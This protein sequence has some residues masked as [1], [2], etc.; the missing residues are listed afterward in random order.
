MIRRLIHPA[1]RGLAASSLVFTLAAAPVWA[2]EKPIVYPGGG[3]YEIVKATADKVWRLNKRTGE[4]AV[5]G[6]EG[7]R[8]VCASAQETSGGKALTADELEARRKLAAETEKRRREEE[9]KKDLAFMDRM[10]D[11]FREFVRAAAERE[12][13]SFG[14]PK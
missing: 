1:I 4:I 11:L 12:T 2:D 9:T 3:D 7:T 8:P 10:I 14:T 6:L 13:A 5:C